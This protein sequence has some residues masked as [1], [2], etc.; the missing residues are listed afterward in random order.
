MTTPKYKP[1]KFGDRYVIHEFLAIGYSFTAIGH[2]LGK[3]KRAV[4]KEVFKHRFL[5]PGSNKL[6]QQCPHTLKPSYV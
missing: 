6:L 1:F 2:R 4:F 3:D 5:K